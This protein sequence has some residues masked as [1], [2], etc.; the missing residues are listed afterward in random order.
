MKKIHKVDFD[1]FIQFKN[2]NSFSKLSGRI[3]HL[4]K[5]TFKTR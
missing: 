3:T 4:K 1:G 5:K 2:K